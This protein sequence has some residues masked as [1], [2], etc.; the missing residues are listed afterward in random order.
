ML[1]NVGEWTHDRWVRGFTNVDIILFKESVDESPRI[2][3]GRAFTNFDEIVRS[4]DRN[5]TAPSDRATNNG[6]RLART[7]R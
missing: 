5:K 2:L 1:G 4:A 6:F 3:R 7:Y